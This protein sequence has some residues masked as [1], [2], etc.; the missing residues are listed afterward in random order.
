MGEHVLMHLAL[1]HQKLREFV[2]DHILPLLYAEK[3]TTRRSSTATAT[4]TTPSTPSTPSATNSPKKTAS[5]NLSCVRCKAV[6]A[7]KA[8][9]RTHLESCEWHCDLCKVQLRDPKR[10]KQHRAKC[11]LEETEEASS[12][13][14]ET[15][16]T[17]LGL[18]LICQL[19]QRSFKNFNYLKSHISMHFR[20]N[21][22]EKVNSWGGG[23]GG[24]GYGCRLC[25]F[26]ANNRD[27]LVTHA[28]YKHALF[29]EFMPPD[30]RLEFYENALKY[31]EKTELWAEH[32]DSQAAN[33][34]TCRKCKKDFD[35]QLSLAS[36]MTNTNCQTVIAVRCLLC[37][38]EVG[39]VMQYKNHLL[40]HYQTNVENEVIGLFKEL[41]GCCKSC[42]PDGS[43]MEFQDFTRHFA[44]EHDKLRNV[45]T[46][47]VKT[48]LS[49]AFPNTS[50]MIR[51][52][53]R[54]L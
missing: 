33:R 17:N 30:M 29:V 35:N 44:L 7:T 12:A 50:S 25:D 18:N 22:K 13:A 43:R 8:E 5:Q 31:G 23:I 19:C 41:G 47:E 21:L 42:H 48:H 28:G 53:W 1:K 39:S 45:L 9:L 24:S 51:Y 52:T 11:G 34:Y 38:I 6:M 26:V 37:D 40:V 27:S 3:S 10:I 54:W 36:H 32:N 46:P 20:S 4:T 14:A 15:T 49:L 16:P 2:P